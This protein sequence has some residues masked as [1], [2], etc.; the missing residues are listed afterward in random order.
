MTEAD[1][2]NLK[3]PAVVVVVGHVDHG[4]TSLLDYIRK[5]NVAGKEA[6]GITQS[7]G[8]YEIEHGGKKIT[9]IDTPGHEAFSKMRERGAKVADVAI[10]VVAG[11][12]SVKPQTQEAIRVLLNS[13]TPFAVAITKMDKPNV[14]LERVKKDLSA[15]NVFLEGYG[16]NVSFQDVS[17][18]TGEG[19]NELLDLILLTSE[20]ED[21]TYSPEAPATGFILESELDS[22][23]GITVSLVLKNGQL[24]AG[25]GIA[26]AS[27]KGKIKILEN[28]LGERVKE[29][30][31]SSP[32]AVLG[33]EAL[34]QLGEEF[35]AG[36]LSEAD[37]EKVQKSAAFQKK[38]SA[39]KKEVSDIRVL[40][41]A[42][43]A[44]SLEALS[45]LVQKIPLKEG[46]K[47]EIVNQGV[48]E[49]TDSD[50][51]EAA[52]TEAVIIGF[53]TYPNKA[54]E[55]LAK[56]QNVTIVTNEI[57]YKLVEEIEKTLAEVFTKKVILSELETLAVFSSQ[58]KK[59]TVG[60]KVISGAIKNK[61]K[62]EI[63]RGEKSAGQARVLELQQ[64]KKVVNVVNAG[65]ECGLQVETDVKIEI[66]DILRVTG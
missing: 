17:A 29:L 50:V 62:L 56:A 46:Q 27:A 4:K 36:K 48:G 42:D 58:G 1:N 23:R 28:F 66:G 6:G 65:N 18:K 41:K 22:R 5:T 51:K 49:I 3:R 35:I 38:I 12:E 2:K 16:G 33:F 45:G 20:M 40:L 43:V 30:I 8:A 34:P 26:T 31:P 15:N 59:Q 52:V 61:A 14:D 24:K 19:I 44:G 63:K 37:L 32:A 64:N 9:F 7:V 39:G 53:R 47:L 60:G 54:A 57:I 21:L 25:D 13:K 10:L 11:D 55:T